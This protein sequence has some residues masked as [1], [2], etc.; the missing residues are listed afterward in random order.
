MLLLLPLFF[1]YKAVFTFQPSLFATSY[2]T[3]YIV[4]V[5][6]SSNEKEIQLSNQ[7]LAFQAKQQNQKYVLLFCNH[8]CYKC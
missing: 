8:F 3:L 4:S 6:T 1:S 2:R 7:F 5:I